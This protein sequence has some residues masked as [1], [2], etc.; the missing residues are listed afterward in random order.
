M[1]VVAV[2]AI[3]F[4]RAWL[5]RGPTII[6]AGS[7]LLRSL[8]VVLL[9]IGAGLAW[10]H[11]WPNS[12]RH[13]LRADFS[14]LHYWWRHPFVAAGLALALVLATGRLRRRRTG[15]SVR[16]RARLGAAAAGTWLVLAVVLWGSAVAGELARREYE[17]ATRVA[18]EDVIATLV[19]R[20]ADRLLTRL[21]NWEP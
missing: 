20:D 10:M 11:F 12:I 13:D 1:L 21:R 18:C 8:V 14:S 7:L 15:G 9:L 17:R 19:G 5:G 4:A 2:A 6:R 16:Y 3:L